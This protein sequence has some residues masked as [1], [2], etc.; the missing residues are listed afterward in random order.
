MADHMHPA[1]PEKI[2]SDY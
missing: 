1:N 2:S